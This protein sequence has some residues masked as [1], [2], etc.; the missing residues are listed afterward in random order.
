VDLAPLV[1]AIRSAIA[2]DHGAYAHAVVL[3]E[4]RTIP[5]TSSGKIQ[6]HACR[7]AFLSGTLEALETAVFGAGEDAASDLAES[8]D[9]RA[10]LASASDPER[11]AAIERLVVREVARV[12]RVP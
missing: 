12:L 5:K 4:A 9:D 10:A 3:L 8:P 6:R 11:G 1:Q 2:E 7:N